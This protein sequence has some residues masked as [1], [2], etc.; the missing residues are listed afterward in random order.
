MS[1]K[2]LELTWITRCAG[3]GWV[4]WDIWDVLWDVLWGVLGVGRGGKADDL[5]SLSPSKNGVGRGRPT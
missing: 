4:G 3:V 5:P 2:L 1:D